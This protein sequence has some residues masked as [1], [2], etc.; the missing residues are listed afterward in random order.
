M[1][2]IRNTNDLLKALQTRVSKALTMT[3]DEIFVVFQRRITEYYK[4]PVFKDGTSAIP[5]LYERTYK[6][7]N[8]LIKT[9]VV[10]TGNSLSCSVEIDPNYLDYT[11]I[12]GASG[13]DVVLSANEQFHGW[14]IEGD[15]RIWDNAL[16]ELGLEY[17]I[18]SLMV[19]NLIK[20]GV[21]IK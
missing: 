7:L 18:R 6:L 5:M 16:E 21:P 20:C 3:R 12:G 8:S 15:I 13:L 10:I 19:K 9:D 17:G 4:E 1:P 14:S 2:L 11:Y